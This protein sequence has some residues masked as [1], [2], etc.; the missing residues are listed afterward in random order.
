[1]KLQLKLQDI[2]GETFYMISSPHN[3]RIEKSTVVYISP[4]L[5]FTV[6]ENMKQMVLL[7]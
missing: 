1:M 5:F 3:Y 2:Y 6:N 4:S 7:E